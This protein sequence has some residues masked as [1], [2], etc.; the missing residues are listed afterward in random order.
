MNTIIA[1]MLVTSQGASEVA[2]FQD[3]DACMAAK[4]QITK[5][6][7]FCTA[8]A[9]VDIDKS[10]DQMSTI[11]SKMAKSMKQAVKEMKDETNNDNI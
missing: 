6:D 1:L 7:S 2:Q 10:L 9:D 4:S 11:L 5:H 8:K 3:M